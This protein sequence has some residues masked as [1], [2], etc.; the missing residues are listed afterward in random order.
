MMTPWKYLDTTQCALATRLTENGDKS[1]FTVKTT[2]TY[3]L[4]ASI[5]YQNV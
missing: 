1:L 4:S 3:E 5:I 2:Y